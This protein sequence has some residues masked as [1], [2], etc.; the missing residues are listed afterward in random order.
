MKHFTLKTASLLLLMN[1]LGLPNID[2]LLGYLYVIGGCNDEE[3]LKSVER[4]DLEEEKW[5]FI[6][7]LS[8]PLFDHAGA[9]DNFKVSI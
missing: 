7:S 2:F 1:F 3:A 9:A 5:S 6:R 8:K 4:F